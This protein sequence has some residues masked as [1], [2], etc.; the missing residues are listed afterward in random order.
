[1]ARRRRRGSSLYYSDEGPP[2]Q[3]VLCDRTED[4]AQEM[5]VGANM[6]GIC[7][8]CIAEANA[9]IARRRHRRPTPTN[10]GAA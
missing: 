10:E 7:N 4:E 9:L 3:C 1:M 8:F 5:I 6:R 2:L